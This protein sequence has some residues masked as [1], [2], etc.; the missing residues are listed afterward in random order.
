VTCAAAD[1]DRNGPKRLKGEW[2]LDLPSP[3]PRSGR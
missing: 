3:T 2:V 1:G